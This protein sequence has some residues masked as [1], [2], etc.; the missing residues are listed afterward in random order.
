MNLANVT[1]SFDKLADGSIHAFAW[2]T[3]SGD[4]VADAVA[5]SA[6]EAGKA[7]YRQLAAK[8]AARGQTIT[9]KNGDKLTADGP[10]NLKGEISN[11]L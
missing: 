2:N 9:S 8:Y 11:A 7:L 10:L 3:D 4:N 1:W 6:V 5:G